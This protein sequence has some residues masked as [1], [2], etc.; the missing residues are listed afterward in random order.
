M[1]TP[2][3]L[4]FRPTPFLGFSVI[5][6]WGITILKNLS[7]ILINP[8]LGSKFVIY[9]E[10]SHHFRWNTVNAPKMVWH[11]TDNCISKLMTH[12]LLNWNWEFKHSSRETV[13]WFH[14]FLTKFSLKSPKSPFWWFLV[15]WML[16][17]RKNMRYDV[18]VSDDI[19]GHTG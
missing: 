16:F 17:W 1:G 15:N 4:L 11:L 13:K 6:L 14:P 9:Y 5:I 2:N 7:K 3:S 8:D 10:M 18:I 19:I 12:Q